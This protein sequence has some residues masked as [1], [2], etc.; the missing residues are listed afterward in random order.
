MVFCCREPDF[1]MLKE[2]VPVLV[3]D[4]DNIWKR[5]I[6]TALILEENQCFVKFESG[7][8]RERVVDIKDTLPLVESAIEGKW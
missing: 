2:S 7:R 3:K 6:I 5:A 4:T 1:D 8:T